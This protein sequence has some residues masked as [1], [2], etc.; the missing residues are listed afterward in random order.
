MGLDEESIRPVHPGLLLP[1]PQSEHIKRKKDKLEMHKIVPLFPLLFSLPCVCAC[2][3][4]LP[5]ASVFDLQWLATTQR[6]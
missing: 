4:L 1:P 2:N 6:L 3:G 5:L